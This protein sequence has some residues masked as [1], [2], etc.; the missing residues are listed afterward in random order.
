MSSDLGYYIGMGVTTITGVQ[1]VI[2]PN[3]YEWWAIML[4]GFFVLAC[5]IIGGIL[6]AIIQDS[7]SNFYKEWNGRKKQRKQSSGG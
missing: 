6:G 7:I 4:L 2:E 5:A 3:K 1:V